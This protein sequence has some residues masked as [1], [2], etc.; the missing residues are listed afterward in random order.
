M[1]R[2]WWHVCR[3]GASAESTK[4]G[5]GQGLDMVGMLWGLGLCAGLDRG[6]ASRGVSRELGCMASW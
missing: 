3:A 6:A 4:Q 5:A 1:W 2:A